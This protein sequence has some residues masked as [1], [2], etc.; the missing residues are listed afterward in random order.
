MSLGRQF[1]IAGI[2]ALG[3]TPAWTLAA[4]KPVIIQVDAMFEPTAAVG[5]ILTKSGISERPANSFKRTAHGVQVELSVAESELVDDSTITA[6]VSGASG[7]RAYGEM[8]PLVAYSPPENIA[9]CP[10]K[11]ARESLDAGSLEQ[12][13]DLRGRRRDIAK[14]QIAAVLGSE[15]LADKLANVEQLFGLN[16]ARPLSADLDPLELLERLA[17]INAAVESY[18]IGRQKPLSAQVTPNPAVTGTPSGSQ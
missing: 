17:R 3:F 13:I 2:L 1:F 7:E 16:S 8:R 18:R 12:L 15:G 5:I 10:D 6:M 14:Q 9:T 11:P 4:D